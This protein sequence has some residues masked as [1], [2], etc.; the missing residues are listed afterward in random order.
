[1][2]LKLFACLSEIAFKG[3]C[4]IKQLLGIVN[5]RL[6]SAV[7]LLT[8]RCLG[9]SMTLSLLCMSLALDTWLPFP[10]ALQ[11]GARLREAPG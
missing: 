9:N 6:N 7:T 10:N 4:L 1:M 5:K 11:R 3:G 2:I 8:H